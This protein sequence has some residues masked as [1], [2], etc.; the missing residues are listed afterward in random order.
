LNEKGITMDHLPEEIYVF[1]ASILEHAG[2]T[3]FLARKGDNKYLGLEGDSAGFDEAEP[4]SA[5]TWLC[6]LTALNAVSLRSRLPW[7]RPVVLGVTTTFG[8]GDRLGL[9]T[10]GHVR[11][12]SG[13]NVSPIF[14][15]QSVRENTRTGR[16]PQQVMD[17]AMWGLFQTGWKEAWGADADHLKA[18]E[19]F[20]P[21]TAA[22]Y[23][24]YTI[25][26]GAYVDDQAAVRS[27]SDLAG[28]FNAL[29]WDQLEDTPQDLIKRMS[30]KHLLP[31]DFSLRIN[32]AAL[33]H[34]AVK[35][36]RAVA[37]TYKMYCQLE[38][39]MNGISFDLEISLDETDFPTSPEEHF[40]V[41]AELHRLNIKFT[42]LAPRFVGR[43][44]KGVEY[45]GDLVTFTAALRWHAAV[46]KMFGDY[47]LSLHSGSDK[48]SIYPILT[49]LLE[50]MIHVKT[51]GTSYLEALRVVRIVNPSLFVEIYALARQRYPFDRLSYHVSAEVDQM[52]HISVS[53]LDPG[54][55]DHF[56]V[57][58][59]LHVTFGSILEKYGEL[60][61]EILQQH[62][63]MYSRTLQEHFSKH[64]LP[65]Q[66]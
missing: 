34:A 12:V 59:I 21:F 54:L 63:E 4:I 1:P 43:F 2:L 51:A 24:F 46:M 41:A 56:H 57:R 42:S 23:T 14:V 65:F 47:R 22:G 13:T 28:S 11:A 8:F 6:P 7:L 32:E 53:A 26:P 5:N 31:G 36:G 49:E 58:E 33:A 60:I 62:E 40:Y 16:T 27:G 39:L 64:L 20:P 45:I 10:P 25:D 3:Y 29:P 52:P 9:A 48:F 17:D 19:D 30:T 50:N 38:K 44:E 37:H 66:K 61:S 35:Y 18:A 55:L 15:Q